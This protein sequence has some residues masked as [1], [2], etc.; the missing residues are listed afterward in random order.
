MPQHHRLAATQSADFKLV[1]LILIMNETDHQGI[2]H[3][4]YNIYLRISYMALKNIFL[5][6]HTNPSFRLFPK[7]NRHGKPVFHIMALIFF[8][9]P[10]A[11]DYNETLQN[12]KWQGK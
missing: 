7:T 5:F 8:L 9:S 10:Y 3:F 6:Q 1:I 11:S 2:N 12:N 4:Y